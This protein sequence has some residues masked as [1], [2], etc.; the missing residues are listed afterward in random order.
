MRTSSSENECGQVVQSQ[1]VLATSH[2]NTVMEWLVK[3]SILLEAPNYLHNHDVIFTYKEVFNMVHRE[4]KAYTFFYVSNYH[5]EP[6]DQ[7]TTD[8]HMIID[9]LEG[10]SQNDTPKPLIKIVPRVTLIY[11]KSYHN[12]LIK[13][14]VSNHV[15]EID[16]KWKHQKSWNHMKPLL[17]YPGDP[18]DLFKPVEEKGERVK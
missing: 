1:V 2:R 17:F 11:S 7:V 16:R 15:D 9:I 8:W 6:P 13:P 4:N 3:M 14:S 10:Y 12:T 5:G 18:G